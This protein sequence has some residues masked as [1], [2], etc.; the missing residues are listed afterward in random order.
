MRSTMDLTQGELVQ[1]S[2]D[3]L[4]QYLLDASSEIADLQAKLSQSDDQLGK[5]NMFAADLISRVNELELQLNGEQA[6]TRNLEKKVLEARS[7]DS[8]E[9]PE[10]YSTKV[11]D[12]Y[13]TPERQ[14]CPLKEIQDHE[15]RGGSGPCHGEI[16]A[17][18]RCSNSMNHA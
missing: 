14:P 9:R 4:H 2:V 7:I 6:I 1:A 5:T 18:G 17:S 16:L 10:M 3:D 11:R 15:G 13:L 12:D 8:S